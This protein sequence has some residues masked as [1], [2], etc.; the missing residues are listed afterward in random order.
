MSNDVVV[1]SKN[2]CVQCDMTKKVLDKRGVSYK[3]LNVDEQPS[4][5]EKVLAMGFRNMPVVAV[6][7]KM[8]AGFQPAQLNALQPA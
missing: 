3:V 4:L 1:Y 8:W 6:G 5:R 7:D 2:Q